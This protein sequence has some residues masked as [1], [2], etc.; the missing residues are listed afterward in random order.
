[1]EI[2]IVAIIGRPNVG[3]ST[4]FNRIVGKRLAIVH[5]DS[6]ITRDRIYQKTDWTGYEFILVDTGGIVP[7]GEA[8]SIEKMVRIQAEI[9]IE[10]ADVII[11]LV[12]ITTGMTYIDK[13]IAKI[14]YKKADKVILAVNKVE[15]QSQ[16]SDI[17]EFMNL[18][19]REPIPIS[20]LHCRNIGSFLD[21]VVKKIP[22]R[23][24]IKTNVNGIKI[25]VVGKQ[26]VGKSSLVNKITGS[27][28]VIV[29]EIP[30]TTRDSINLYLQYKKNAFTIIDT[31][32]LRKKSKI[33][34]GIEY[35]SAIRSLESIDKSD[36][37]LLMIDAVDGVS[38]QDK[39]I[40]D[41][42]KRNYKDIII[43]VNKWDLIDKDNYTFGDHIKAIREN[44]SF[45]DYAPIIFISALTGQRVQKLLDLI[46]KVEQASHSRIS[47]SDLN[48]FIQLVI[49]KFPPR[50]PS[51]KN[52]KI[53]YCTQ[54]GVHPPLFVFFVNNPKFITDSYKR[55]LH[56]QLREQFKFEG[57]TIRLKF[58]GRS[59][60]ANSL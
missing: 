34:Y 12:D 17:Y 27:K 11:F 6:G 21:E 20:A 50:H 36:I 55:Y 19:L 39:K 33:K 14:L 13:D 59:Q 28:N 31:A 29:S 51:R 54:T 43:V 32:G 22:K 46:I 30:G 35:F 16:K 9:A 8:N 41:Y 24:P 10:Q 1:V 48:E 37:T 40:A 2:P 49:K 60:N 18:G 5:S 53:Y 4:L 57:A 23:H 45:I 52:I 15:K 58:K 56:N 26:N 3:K 7:E 47:T 38:F 42:V 44:L 25:A